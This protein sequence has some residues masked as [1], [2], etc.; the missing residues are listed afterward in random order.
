MQTKWFYRL[1][2]NS[3]KMYTN[4][5]VH[6]KKLIKYNFRNCVET[7]ELNSKKYLLEY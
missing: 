1:E 7:T 3:K 4:L 6:L 5:M 2:L